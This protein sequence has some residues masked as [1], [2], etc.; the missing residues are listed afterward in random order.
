MFALAIVNNGRWWV[1]E[2]MRFSTQQEAEEYKQ[3]NQH[4][5]M[6]ELHTVEESQ[7]REVTSVPFRFWPL[8]NNMVNSNTN[9]ESGE[10]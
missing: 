6:A 9:N 8:D 10:Q 5:Y 4:R 1:V 3:N 7:D 2:S